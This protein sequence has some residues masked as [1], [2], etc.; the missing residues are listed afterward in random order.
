MKTVLILGAGFAGLEL[1]TKLSHEVPHD[2][3]VTIIDSSDAFVFGFSKLDLMFGRKDLASVRV[4]YA[5][6][7]KP[8]VRFAQETALTIDPERRRVTTNAATYE[9]D[10]LVVAL[11]ADLDPAATPGLVEEG[12]EF[13][14]VE[15]ATRVQRL[16]PAFE[17]GDVIVGVLGNFFK[18]PAAPFEAALMLHDFLERRGRRAASTINVV[19]P[20]ATPIPISPEASAGILEALGERDIGW[21]PQSKVTSLDPAAKTATLA[22]GQTMP[23]DLFLGIP[24]HRA[25]RVVEES[26]LA[27]EGWIP[28]DHRTFATKF[29]GVYAV[30]DVT[31]APVP[32]VGAIAEG[33]ART[34]AEVLVHQ[35]KGGEAPQS[36][37]GTATCYIEFGGSRVARFDA[38]FLS[39]PSPFGTFTPASEDVAG[40]KVEF[41]ASRRRRWFGVD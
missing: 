9:P 41:G 11:G 20:M 17:G 26:A 22:D 15:G 23:Y 18:C 37:Q 7:D 4:P 3:D 13:Y 40:L 33:E 25:P 31:S 29:E 14:S 5:H 21:W 6:L 38:N 36:Y 24:V 1:A 27:E 2:V 16:L 10:I 8:S 30:G 35:I 12:S 19:S 28:V 39:G 32:R 34:L